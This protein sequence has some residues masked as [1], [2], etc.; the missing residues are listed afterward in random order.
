MAVSDLLMA[1]PWAGFGI[2]RRRGLAT[3]GWGDRSSARH[4]GRAG[5][6]ERAPPMS[7]GCYAGLP[8]DTT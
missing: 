7:F 2:G 8:T 6:R 1:A 4:S 3:I 5:A